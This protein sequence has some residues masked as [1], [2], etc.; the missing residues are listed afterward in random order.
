M[1]NRKA[2]ANRVHRTTV[3]ESDSDGRMSGE[4]DREALGPLLPGW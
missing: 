2:G 3:H 1:M 4:E